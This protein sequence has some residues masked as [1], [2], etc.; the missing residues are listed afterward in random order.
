LA[1][2]SYH[3]FNGALIAA[4][5]AAL[6]VMLEAP[7]DAVAALLVP[8]LAPAFAGFTIVGFFCANPKKVVVINR[9][10]RKA[11]RIILIIKRLELDL[12]VK[13]SSHNY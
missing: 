1:G 11:L 9:V 12:N 6:D 8:D 4:L 13:T 7:L 2:L 10:K 5:M 3:N